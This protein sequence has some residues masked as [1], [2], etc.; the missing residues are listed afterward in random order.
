MQRAYRNRSERYRE[1]P[2]QLKL[3]FGNTPEAAD[4]AEGLAAAVEEAEEIIVKEH[5]RRRHKPRKVRDESFPAH[6]PRYEVTLEVPEDVKHCAEHGERKLIGYDR[7]ET[8]EFERPKL[9]V[10]VTLIPKFACE[11]RAGLRREG[12]AAAGGPGG[13]QPLRHERGRRD[14]HRQVWLPPADLSPAGL[15]R[16]QRLDAHRGARS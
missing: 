3:D 1:D 2:A 9:K 12:S 5:K 11:G 7:Q 8:L 6:L 13:R 15:F 4:A 14:H 16:G 10:R